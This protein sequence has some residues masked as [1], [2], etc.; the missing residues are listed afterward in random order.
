MADD[1]GRHHFLLVVYGFQSHLNPGRVL[2]H[3]LARLGADG[4][5]LATLSVPAATYRRMFP[6]PDAAATAETTTTDGVISYVPYSDGVDDGS[7]GKDADDRALRRRA[8]SE[9]LSAIVARFANR[10]QPVTCIM[11]TMMLLPVLD[12]ARERNIPVAI[13]W[14]QPATLLAITYHYFHGYDDLIASHAT[15]PAYEV[16]LP[17]LSRPLE[18]SNFP[19]FLTDTSGSESTKAFIEVFQ[20]LFE[21]MDQWRPKVLVNTFGELEANVLREMK[22]HLDVFTVGP[23][24]GSSTE[25][26]IHL[27]KHDDVDEKRYMEWLQAHPEK[28]VVYVSSGSVTKY[29]KRQMD[30]IVGGLRQCGRPYL[31]VVR[32]DDE[33]HSL[34]D[35]TQGQGMVVEW[36]NQLEVLSHSAVGCFVSHCGWNSTIEAMAS[37]VPIIGV[38]NMFDQPTNTYLVDKEWEIG[39]KG[40]RNGDGVLTGTELARCIELVMGEGAKAKAIRERAK[41]LKEMAQAS[42]SRGGSAER[43]LRDFVKTIQVHDTFCMTSTMSKSIKL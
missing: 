23:M 43:N 33:S 7:W 14:I 16:C 12:V 39:I 13:C 38:P 1:E 4:S 27:F 26:R 10:G 22:R 9:S 32:K 5:V 8:S 31:L 36:C 42:A 18:I 41:A 37:G 29:T 24:V 28:S 30:E 40:E 17:G 15:D 2:A 21:Y 35:H 20:E 3:R 11:C 6:S 34:E 19:S 25:A